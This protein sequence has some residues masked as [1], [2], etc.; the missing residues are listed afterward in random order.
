MIGRAI[1]HWRTASTTAWEQNLKWYKSQGNDSPTREPLGAC[2]L[3]W[4]RSRRVPRRLENQQA[5]KPG[6][7]SWDFDKDEQD[8]G[9]K[10]NPPKPHANP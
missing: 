1:S 10:K 4:T 2:R 3:G 7:E 8:F 6:G 9:E 5:S